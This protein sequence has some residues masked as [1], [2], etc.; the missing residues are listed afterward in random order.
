MPESLKASTGAGFK[1]WQAGG[2][3][4]AQQACAECGELHAWLLFRHRSA[5]LVLAFGICEMRH[6][7]KSS[8]MVEDSLQAWLL[9]LP[10]AAEQFDLSSVL[11]SA[12][13]CLCAGQITVRSLFF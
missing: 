2:S 9:L 5:H 13:L 12:M 8:H 6:S 7:I 11:C 4:A 3:T 1:C 10:R